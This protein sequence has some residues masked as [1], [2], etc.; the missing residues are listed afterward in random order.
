MKKWS[1][2]FGH[3]RLFVFHLL[4]DVFFNLNKLR[5]YLKKFKKETTTTQKDGEYKKNVSSQKRTRERKGKRKDDPTNNIQMF[6]L[7]LLFFFPLL[8]TKWPTANR[9]RSELRH[10]TARRR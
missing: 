3:P 4:F 8:Y 5:K 1:G 2:K 6:L 9:E 7:L 10:V